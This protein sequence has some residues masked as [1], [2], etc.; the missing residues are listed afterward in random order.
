MSHITILYGTMK[1][2][3]KL[4]TRGQPWPG[5]KVSTR[6]LVFVRAT[7][8]IL[9]MPYV[10]IGPCR[11]GEANRAATWPVLDRPGPFLQELAGYR[12]NL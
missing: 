8:V 11:E 4:W 9:G 5:V 1:Q 10:G 3:T 2:E 6:E 7:A 12:F